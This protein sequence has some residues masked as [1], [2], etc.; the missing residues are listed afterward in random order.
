MEWFRCVFTI[1]NKDYIK[2]RTAKPEP[3]WNGWGWDNGTSDFGYEFRQFLGNCYSHMK[4]SEIVDGMQQLIHQYYMQNGT[5]NAKDTVA[6]I[7]RLC[8]G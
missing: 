6:R 1:S 2:P 5:I 4:E 8:D 7:R 3:I